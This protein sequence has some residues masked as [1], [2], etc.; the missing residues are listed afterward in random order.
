MRLAT[1]VVVGHGFP[2]H[3]HQLLEQKNSTP[4]LYCSYWYVKIV[5]EC[6]IM[7]RGYVVVFFS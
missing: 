2:E 4:L 3:W 7:R 1:V 6:I 5:M